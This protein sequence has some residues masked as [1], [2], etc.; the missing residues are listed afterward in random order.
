MTK[1]NDRLTARRRKIFGRPT[2]GFDTNELFLQPWFLPRRNE[3]AMRGLMP[4]DYRSKMHACFEDYG[5]LICGRYDEY[6]ANG[7]CIHC[8]AKVRAKL[9]KSLRRRMRRR[10]DNNVSPMLERQKGLA[11]MLLGGFRA[12]VG[13]SSRPYRIEPV[14]AINPVDEFLAPQPK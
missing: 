5:C 9:K 10:P 11:K 4:P 7:M 8:N 1:R 12:P 3:R 2:N 13:A 6:F 14:P